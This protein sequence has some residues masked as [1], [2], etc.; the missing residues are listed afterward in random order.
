MTWTTA[1]EKCPFADAVMVACPALIART[2]PLSSTVAIAGADDAQEN[3]T[4]VSDPPVRS[5]AVATSRV[6][7]LAGFT[8][9]FTKIVSTAGETDTDIVAGKITSVA[10]PTLSADALISTTP[11]VLGVTTPF[12]STI[13][14]D[15]SDVDHANVIA[16]SVE[17]F[18]PVAV[19]EK[20]MRSDARMVSGTKIVSTDGLTLTELIRYPGT[21]LRFTPVVS[22]HE[23]TARM[24]MSSRKR[25]ARMSYF[26]HVR[27]RANFRFSSEARR[28]RDSGRGV[29]ACHRH[30]SRR[31]L[32]RYDSQRLL[33]ARKPH[34]R[35][36]ASVEYVRPKDTSDA[37]ASLTG[38]GTHA[39]GGGTDLLVT[40]REG[41]V[42][43]AR[44]VDLRAIPDGD[45]ITWGSDGSLRLGA[46]ATIA[47]IAANERIRGQFAA[48]AMACDAVGS[49]ALRNMGTIG[50]N[51]C[52][53][54]RCWYFRSGI[55][56]LKSDGTD[57]PAADGENTHHAIFGGGPCYAVH[58]S[59]PAVA[60]TALEASV[61]IAGP[62]GERSVPIGEFLVLPDPDPKRET[63]LDPG[64]FISAIEVPAASAGGRQKYTKIL[65]RGAWDFALASLAVV[66]RTDDSVRMVLGGVAPVPWRVNP[67][68]EEDVSSAPLSED[69]VDV[70]ADRALYDAK[71]LARNAYKISL[72]R[73]LLRE[74]IAFAN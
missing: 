41:L 21:S 19:A 54:P 39:L 55:P 57:C 65:Q 14:I 38:V 17:P 22:V 43:P 16:G 59:D 29:V 35:R 28:V 26:L 27:A 30:L 73:A 44:V 63:V 72:A 48:L 68:V 52:Q 6:V 10:C 62:A 12:S 3:V 13:A 69:D 70:L 23:R 46:T 58:A 32:L 45:A 20:M 50:G 4:P 60:L 31:P 61:T 7:S 67:S 24:D 37:S 11:S 74:A 56:C 5:R 8:T 18:F 40:M 47:T 49:P 42:R 34:H 15:G 33:R 71:P 53:R 2:N 64:E 66:R 51:L 25:R 9:W 36:R 1:A